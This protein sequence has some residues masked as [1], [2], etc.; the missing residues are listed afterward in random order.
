MLGT[1]GQATAVLDL[2]TACV[3][4]EDAPHGIAVD[5]ERARDGA[6]R[7]ALLGEY[8]DPVHELL[9]C[10]PRGGH[11]G[12]VGVVTCHARSQRSPAIM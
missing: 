6:C 9:A 1:P 11:A 4:S 10:T 12:S 3:C 2:A 8:E 5:P 7:C